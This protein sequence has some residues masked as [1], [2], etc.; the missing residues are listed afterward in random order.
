M[1]TTKDKTELVLLDQQLALNAYLEALLTEAGFDGEDE[2]AVSVQIEEIVTDPE[3]DPSVSQPVI[4]KWALTQTQYLNFQ[5]TDMSL[6]APLDQLSGIIKA[7]DPITALPGQASWLK[8]LLSNRGQQVK[9]IDTQQI[10][11]KG[12]LHSQEGTDYKYIM[13]IDEG[14]WG[15]TCD[16]VTDVASRESSE[17]KWRAGSQM[18]SFLAGTVITDLRTVVDVETLVE[19]LNSGTMV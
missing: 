14:R 15:L 19:E 5:V 7:K 3:P 16:A 10:V 2:T 8:G 18:L 4:P 9:I 13:L 6:T 17:I 1:G 12:A 11:R